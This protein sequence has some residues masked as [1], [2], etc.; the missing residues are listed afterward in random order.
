MKI[1]K[2]DKKISITKQCELLG[3]ATPTY[4]YKKRKTKDRFYSELKLLIDKQYIATPFYGTRRM[5]YI[6]NQ[7][8]FKVNRKRV[9]RLMREM[10][11]QAIYPKKNL[12]KACLGH[13]KYPYLLKNLPITKPNQV[14]C[15]DITYIPMT[16]GNVYLTVV[17]DW[18]SRYILSYEISITMDNSFCI[19][20]LNMA[21]SKNKPE[22]FNSDQGSQFTSIAYT[23]IL[24]DNDISISMDGRGRAF[25]NIFIERLWRSLKYEEVYLKEYNTVKEAKEGIEKWINF[26]N[27]KRPHSSQGNQT[28]E[29]V[30]FNN[31]GKNPKEENVA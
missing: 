23:N 30:Y 17:M 3:L 1:E 12:S 22:I 4:Y 26:Y 25:D 7:L 14:W 11:L 2:T 29:Y 31:Q 16:K 18:Y 28:P 10:G 19:D 20:A 24:K 15:T 21:L 5:K 13:K 27:T 8:G 6:L 9:Q